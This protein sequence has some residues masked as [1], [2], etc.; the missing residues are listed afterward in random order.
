[1]VSNQHGSFH[2]DSSIVFMFL[3]QGFLRQRWGHSILAHSRKI[4]DDGLVKSLQG[5]HSRERGSPE[6]ADFPGFPRSRE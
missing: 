1:M 3:F 4:K 5:R 2:E 6:M